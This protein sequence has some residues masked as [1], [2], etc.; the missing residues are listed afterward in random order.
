MTKNVTLAFEDLSDMKV[1]F[2]F[3][4]GDRVRKLTEIA[5]SVRKTQASKMHA[6]LTHKYTRVGPS[7]LDTDPSHNFYSWIAVQVYVSVQSQ[8]CWSFRD[9]RGDCV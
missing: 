7:W 3:V 2:E 1:C 5:E 6:P 9:Y 8:S 4:P